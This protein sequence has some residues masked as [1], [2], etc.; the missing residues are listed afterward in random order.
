MYMLFL[1]NASNI[2]PSYHMIRIT[3]DAMSRS[4]EC[5]SIILVTYLLILLLALRLSVCPMTHACISFYRYS[6]TRRQNPYEFVAL[7]I[8]ML[9]Y[10]LLMNYWHAF[11]VSCC[12]LRSQIKDQSPDLFAFLPQCVYA[13]KCV[14][15]RSVRELV[16]YVA[17]FA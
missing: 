12:R 7:Y 3:S 5:Y 8:Y 17:L 15:A 2:G 14:C 13:L 1:F 9:T 4:D 10:E 11:E 6:R 16:V